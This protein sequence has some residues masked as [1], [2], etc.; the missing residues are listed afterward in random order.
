[1]RLKSL[2]LAA[3]LVA[4]ST[5]AFAAPFTK[6]F[7]FGDSTSDNGNLFALTGG[8]AP[9]PP[10]LPGRASNGPVAAEYLSLALGLGPLLPAAVGGTNF[11]VIGAATGNVP[12]PGGG[13]ADNIAA[14]IPLPPGVVLPPTGMSTAQ[15]ARFFLMNPG[16]ID[17]N[18]LFLVWGG[19]NDLGI[20]PSP[21]VA[22]QAA[23]NIGLIIDTLYGAGARNFLIPNMADLGLTPRN[24]GAEAAASFLTTVFNTTLAGQLAARAG[25][26][27]ISLTGFNTFNL[28]NA[29][30]ASPQT[31]GFT[32]V[33]DECYQG[34]LL[35][36]GG[37]SLVCAT[38]NSYLFWDQIH[39]SGAAHA[40]LGASFAAAVQPASVP[41]PA[42]MLL[43]GLG[44]AAVAVRRR[45]AD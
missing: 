39:P 22:A 12:L 10:Y 44:V 33:E 30:V 16:P 24:D 5:S 40:L 18:A 31:Y 37:P 43:A 29:V 17:P 23:A 45:R 20:N 7:V 28:F 41:E 32:N 34:P 2:I 15:L 27:G 14:T 4:S 11:A 35:G 3:T 9:A 26:P 19:P 36:V 42:T 25:L 21:A 1:M 8:L 6:L 38:P 13:T